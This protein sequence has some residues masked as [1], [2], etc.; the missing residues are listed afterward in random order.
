MRTWPAMLGVYLFAWALVWSSHRGVC[1]RANHSHWEAFWLPVPSRSLLW[2]Q[3]I[4]SCLAHPCYEMWLSCHLLFF[5]SLVQW[6]L[7][8]PLGTYLLLPGDVLLGDV[9]WRSLL[10]LSSPMPS[11]V[12]IEFSWYGIGASGI[13]CLLISFFSWRCCWQLPML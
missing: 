3:V 7:W 11:S 6:V 4:L 13:S 10:S 2:P 8:Y 9:L 1:C 12:W 5:D